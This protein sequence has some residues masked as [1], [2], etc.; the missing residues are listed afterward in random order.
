MKLRN[1]IKV[2]RTQRPS[3]YAGLAWEI[4]TSPIEMHGRSA[5]Q[6]HENPATKHFSPAHYMLLCHRFLKRSSV[7][8]DFMSKYL[9][10]YNKL[11]PA[12]GMIDRA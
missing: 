2:K 12:K 8:S 3:H 5:A 9:P 7:K 6:P 10:I 11:M 1:Y 4:A